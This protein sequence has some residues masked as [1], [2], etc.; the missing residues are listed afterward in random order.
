MKRII[1]FFTAIIVLVAC[2]RE[3]FIDLNS[4]HP[5]I[6]IEANV[7]DD[8]SQSY[9]KLSKTL[10]F[11]DPNN[12]PP[13]EG[14]EVVISDNCGVVD[15]L[16]EVF[17]GYYIAMRI[18]GVPGRTYSLTIKYGGE[19]YRATSKMPH[20]VMLDSLRFYQSFPELNDSLYY[21]VPLFLDPVRT[22]D[23]YR[24]IS[25]INGEKDRTYFVFSDRLFNGMVNF[26]PVLSDDYMLKLGDTLTLEMRCI[27]YN[28]YEYF[29]VINNVTGFNYFSPPANPLNNITGDYALGYFS[30]HSVQKKTQIVM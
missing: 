2:E 9:V 27:D 8:T 10:N 22:D 18:E 5:Q 23:Q 3:I 7:S 16:V 4:S 25:Y 28:I 17:P 29:R 30:A 11:S 13:V 15:T 19:T 24:F 14:A 1:L 20:V 12:Y 21:V 6:I 26:R